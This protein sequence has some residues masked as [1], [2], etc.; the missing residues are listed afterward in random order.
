MSSIKEKLVKKK[1]F[2]KYLISYM[3]V[4]ILPIL[5]ILFHFYPE[6]TKIIKKEAQG[7]EAV[8]LSQINDYVSI[9]VDSLF[10]CASAIHLSRD[11][12]SNLFFTSNEFNTLLIMQELKKIT[13]TN[14]FIERAF[15]YSA[16]NGKFYSHTGT[17]S[18]D[19][20]GKHGSSFYYENWKQEDIINLL[21]QTRNLVI[22]PSE[23][24]I[25]PYGNSINAVTFIIPIPLGSSLPY[26]VLMIVVEEKSFFSFMKNEF[27]THN[28]NI[29]I[30]DS[31]NVPI[32]KKEDAEYLYTDEFISLL[33][34]F[35]TDG[36][37]QSK[38]LG[39]DY[40]ISVLKSD[41]PAFKYV[42]LTPVN[43]L[44]KEL[45]ISK[46]NTLFFVFIIVAAGFVLIIFAMIINYRP[47]NIIKKHILSR[48]VEGLGSTDDFQLIQ[49]AILKLQ[50]ENKELVNRILLNKN[51]ISEYF[52]IQFINGNIDNEDN[53]IENAAEYGIIL[54][55][56]VC[57]FTF[58]AMDRNTL[59]LLNGFNEMLKLNSDLS[60]GY[61]IKGM[62]QEDFILILTFDSEKDIKR[63]YEMLYNMISQTSGNIKIGIGTI[64][65][66]LDVNKA[67]ILSLVALENAII[68]D[69]VSV[70]FYD[71]IN[72]EQNDDLIFFFDNIKTL[73]IA[74]YRNDLKQM[75]FS[76]DN[77]IKLIKTRIRNVFRLRTVYITAHNLFI[78]ELKKYGVE[79]KFIYDV[80]E[81]KGFDVEYA[82]MSLE[83]LYRLLSGK[84]G[85]N[86]DCYDRGLPDISEIILYLEDN[87]SD[88]N[89]SLQYLACKYNTTYSNFSHYFKK[90]T[91]ENFSTY[92]ERIRMRHAKELLK[93]NISIDKIASVVGYTNANSFNRAFK[94]QEAT[95]PG[96][97]RKI[98]I[99][100]R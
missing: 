72:L 92:L 78:K 58:Y 64:E 62:R 9:Q 79:R 13:G 25:L 81:M 19:E 94:R 24:V 44:L 57:C 2:T 4:F 99:E 1:T 33:E 85:M 60:A 11:I 43:D 89:L 100:N 91:K 65:D 56:K 55:D 29:I 54:K 50:N 48:A 69:D 20:F 67:Y 97:Y 37:M 71:E 45:N 86:K 77:I 32:V 93:T 39:T 63:Y 90:N 80:H 7:S 75:R 34:D 18:E 49:Q 68:E 31:N 88:C 30:L 16:S 21:N 73:E 5:L 10:N 53:F 28:G 84:I 41:S 15:L 46:R 35:D 51:I 42:S 74:I 83:E 87:Y 76:M 52:L 12:T 17:I 27:E 3:L 36:F 38:L 6:T 40:I 14:P 82:V 61:L 59:Q 95:T 8:L 98:Q 47:I 22:R 66:L 26:S 23:K 96:E 70:L